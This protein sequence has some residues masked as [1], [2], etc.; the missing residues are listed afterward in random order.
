MTLTKSCGGHGAHSRCCCSLY[1]LMISWPTRQREGR[2]VKGGQRNALWACILSL[3]EFFVPFGKKGVV[4]DLLLDLPWHHQKQLMWRRL[5]WSP[6][7]F[8]R[9]ADDDGTNAERLPPCSLPFSATH[10][11]TGTHSPHKL[12]SSRNT[13]SNHTHT[14]AFRKNFQYFTHQH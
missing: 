8:W 13:F 12:C 6:L 14:R 1:R 5:Y 7:A 10:S 3:L 11:N 4:Y 2:R 9:D